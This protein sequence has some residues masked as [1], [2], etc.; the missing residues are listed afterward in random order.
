MRVGRYETGADLFFN[1]DPQGILFFTGSSSDRQTHVSRNLRTSRKKGDGQEAA[2]I[3]SSAPR[4]RPSLRSKE[5]KDT[6]ALQQF[7]GVRPGKYI[8]TLDPKRRKSTLPACLPSCPVCFAEE[9]G[10][11]SKFPKARVVRPLI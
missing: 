8:G 6:H 2:E 7:S 1:F 11:R 5:K 10:T 9:E 3:F 4:N